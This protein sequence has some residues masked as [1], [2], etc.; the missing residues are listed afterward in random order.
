M[1]HSILR[2]ID[3]LLCNKHLLSCKND[4]LLYKKTASCVTKTASRVTK[5]ASY[6]ARSVC[7]SNKLR[8]SVVLH[9]ASCVTK[10][11][12]C[13]AN[14]AGL[15]NNL[16]AKTKHETSRFSCPCFA[17]QSHGVCGT[18]TSIP[19]CHGNSSITGRGPL[20]LHRRGLRG[21]GREVTV[22]TPPSPSPSPQALATI[23]SFGSH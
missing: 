12:C 9:T 20:S 5:T 19:R 15:D 11:A 23:N 18:N 17:R 3:W 14:T 21:A 22:R 16:A 13:E 7:C 8:L 1:R 4:R 6:V 2:N 10:T